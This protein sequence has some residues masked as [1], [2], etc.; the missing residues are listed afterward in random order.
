MFMVSFLDTLSAYRVKI[1]L[2]A[3]HMKGTTRMPKTYLT[4][5]QRRKAMVEKRM[6][7]FDAIVLEYL[8]STGF[9]TSDLSYELGIDPST[10]CS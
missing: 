5:E 3:I 6:D 9:T 8:R 10:S 1:A 7:K 2:P 4:E